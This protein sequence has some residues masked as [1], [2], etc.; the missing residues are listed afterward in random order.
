MPKKKRKTKKTSNSLLKYLLL[1]IIFI[2]LISIIFIMFSNE[3]QLKEH[4]KQNNIK[5]Q[6]ELNIQKEQFKYFEEKTKAMEIEYSQDTPIEYLD[7]KIIDEKIIFKFID[8][9][10]QKRQKVNKKKINKPKIA[11]IIDDVTTSYQVKK[12]LSIPYPVTMSFL[13]PTKRHK[14]SSLISKKIPIYMIHLPLEASNWNLEEENTLH[15]GDS[16]ATIEKRIAKIKQWYPNTKYINNHTGSKFTSNR[17]SMEKLIKVL[18]KYNYTFLDSKTASHTA[19]KEYA[20]KYN[21]PYLSR[22]I[23]LDNNQDENY[24][25]GQLKKTIKIAKKR[26]FAIAIGHPHKITLKT[27][28]K[29]KYLFKD[30]DVVLIDKI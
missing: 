4:K 11:I 3:Q 19:T 17:A 13:P 10:K 20:T 23:F 1:L 27:L 21:L 22:N 30:L 14:Y 8:N 15:V 26:G 5:K 2:I 9:Q 24:I 25:F 28:S 16:L 12:I 18:K 6:Q 7:E 29:A